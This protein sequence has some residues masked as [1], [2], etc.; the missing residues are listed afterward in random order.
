MKSICR[1]ARAGSSTRSRGLF[2]VPV[3]F[4][5]G[6]CFGYEDF[7]NVDDRVC[8]ER[9]TFSWFRSCDGR[10]KSSTCPCGVSSGL[11]KGDRRRSE[12]ARQL[13]VGPSVDG[14]AAAISM[15][16]CAGLRAIGEVLGL[17]RDKRDSICVGFCDDMPA[18]GSA[19]ALRCDMRGFST[20]RWDRLLCAWD[21]LRPSL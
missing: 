14:G 6:C 2:E 13:G 9:I 7:S 1:G 21:A 19:A 11:G 3:M 18:A 8:W 4:T 12:P 15:S 17:C 10:R 16:I 5:P 20:P